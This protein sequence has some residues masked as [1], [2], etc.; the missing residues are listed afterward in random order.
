MSRANGTENPAL[1]YPLINIFRILLASLSIEAIL[2]EPTKYLRQER[3]R[4]VTD[5]LGLEDAYG[6]VIERIK[7]QDENEARLAMKALIWIILLIT[8]TRPSP[9][10][11]T[12]LLVIDF[13]GRKC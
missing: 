2:H 12:I 9:P 6:T 4:K 11:T 10:I 3:L 1:H 7:G 13:E 8:G 5:R